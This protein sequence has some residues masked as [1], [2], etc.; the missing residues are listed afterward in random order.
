MTPSHQGRRCQARSSC[1]AAPCLMRTRW[2]GTG[3]RTS[4]V[5]ARVANAVSLTAGS[6]RLCPHV[7]S[8]RERYPEHV[9]DRKSCEL[10]LA[11]GAGLRRSFTAK[12][13]GHQPSAQRPVDG[14]RLGDSV[15]WRPS[16]N[17]HTPTA[18]GERDSTEAGSGLHPASGDALRGSS[19]H[20]ADVPSKRMARAAAAFGDLILRSRDCPS[21]LGSRSR[22]GAA[23]VGQA[24]HHPVELRQLP[25]EHRSHWS[26]CSRA[27][28][29]RE[30]R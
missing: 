12:D 17:G 27:A 19:H 18:V 16:C 26:R 7:R 21:G 15:V 22:F 5:S 3:R 30:D 24:A 10:R 20:P 14:Y 9:E 25:A 1:G 29:D 13:R 4:L 2:P 11:V 6:G 23:S 28:S 8:I